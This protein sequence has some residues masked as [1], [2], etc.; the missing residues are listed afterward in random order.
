MESD[1]ELII[2]YGII[3]LFLLKGAVMPKVS[4]KELE[5]FMKNNPNSHAT[6]AIKEQLRETPA[7]EPNT[8]GCSELTA[9]PGQ[10]RNTA[11]YLE[12]EKVNELHRE[13]M[14]SFNERISKWN[15]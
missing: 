3:F 5:K 15:L 13:V 10:I 9:G 8:G 11:S 14:D 2:V 12:A 7:P 4:M 1:N 6:Q